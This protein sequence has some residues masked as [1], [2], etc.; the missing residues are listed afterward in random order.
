MINVSGMLIILY[1]GHKEIIELSKGYWR[2]ELWGAASGSSPYGDISPKRGLGAFVSGELSLYHPLNLYCYVGGVGEDNHPEKAGTAGFNGGCDG[3]ND[4][5]GDPNCFSGG[6]GGATDVRLVEDDL[7]SRII[8][9]G[10]GG[11]PGCSEYSGD[12]GSGGTIS[13]INGSNPV[14]TGI[15]GKGGYISIDSP[16][17]NGTKGTDGNE[18][19][20]SGG[21]G[22]FAGEGGTSGV[23]NGGGGGGG[24]SSY[25]SGC[26]GCKTLL[27]NGQLGTN[28]HPSSLIFHN[29]TMI[30]GNETTIPTFE[31]S[32]I[33]YTPHSKHGLIVIT[34]LWD[35]KIFH[36]YN[37]HF[38]NLH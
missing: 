18:A 23:S 17:G 8:V 34:K 36:S 11:S 29:I 33:K 38:F 22:Y 37:Q 35:I 28:V 7:Y 19:A 3:A 13:G 14:G 6:S 24:G 10:G 5:T 20:G 1:S 25:V 26:E 16:F 15:G 4:D 30:S 9:A 32:E 12:G 21:G 2:F 31:H 27:S